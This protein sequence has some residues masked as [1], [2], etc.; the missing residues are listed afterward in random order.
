MLGQF[1]RC[2]RCQA[3]LAGSSWR[4]RLCADCILGQMKAVT[5]MTNVA[6][7]GVLLAFAYGVRWWLVRMNERPEEHNSVTGRGL[8]NNEGRP[9]R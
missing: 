1:P 3:R 8:G 5:V 7:L 9:T 6:I 4:P 2:T